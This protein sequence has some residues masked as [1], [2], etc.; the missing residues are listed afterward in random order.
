MT[1]KTMWLSIYHFTL[2]ERE[3]HDSLSLIKC[4]DFTAG[5]DYFAIKII[6]IIL[7][8]ISESGLQGKHVDPKQDFVFGHR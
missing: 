3:I 6:L 8:T 1:C 7:E 4:S 5:L 2:N